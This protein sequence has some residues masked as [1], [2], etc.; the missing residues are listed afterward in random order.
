MTIRYLRKEAANGNKYTRK[1]ELELFK[2]NI[3]ER[4]NFI[5]NVAKIQETKQDFF[6][7]QGK[8]ITR[9]GMLNTPKGVVTT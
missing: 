4:L 8:I 3:R 2:N 7:I 1:E 9:E 5:Y 6:R